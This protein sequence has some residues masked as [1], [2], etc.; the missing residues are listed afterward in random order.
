[1]A[2][3]T[4]PVNDKAAPIKI[5]ITNDKMQITKMAAEKTGAVTDAVNKML[6]KISGDKIDFGSITKAVPVEPVKMT[7]DLKNATAD[8]NDHQ[9]SA[10]P[11]VAVPLVADH[12][13]FVD[14]H[15]IGLHG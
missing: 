15:H 5:S 6:P 9:P 10:H 12:F 7:F 14:G 11:D 4:T 2:G 1:M 3:L 13:A 8:G